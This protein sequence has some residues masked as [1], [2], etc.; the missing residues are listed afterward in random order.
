MKSRFQCKDLHRPIG[1]VRGQVVQVIMM[2][3]PRLEAAPREVVAQAVAQEAIVEA[4]HQEVAAQAVAEE[5]IVAAAEAARVAGQVVPV[6]VTKKNH[7]C[8]HSNEIYI[9][10]DLE[11]DL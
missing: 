7:Q 6:P 5:A 1:V 3:G 10:S 2:A 8:L 9:A 4:V 11:S